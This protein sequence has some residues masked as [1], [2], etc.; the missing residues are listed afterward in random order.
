MPHSEKLLDLLRT[1]SSARYLYRH[2]NNEYV[3]SLRVVL[4]Q[5]GFSKDLNWKSLGDAPFYGEETVIAVRNFSRRNNKFTDGA[6]VSPTLL[7]QMVHL[8]DALVGIDLLQRA[9]AADQLSFSFVPTDPESFGTQQLIP[10]LK[11]LGIPF[12]DV[13][14]GLRTFARQQGLSNL[15][16]TRM[17]STLARALMAALKEKYGPDKNED[18]NQPAPKPIEKPEEPLK[19]RP[20]EPIDP[21]PITTELKIVDSDDYVLVSDGSTQVQFRKRDLGVVTYGYHT[22]D[23][24]VTSNRDQLIDAG[25]VPEGINVIEAVS[26]NEGRMDSINTYDR[27]F[28]SLG[29][30]QWTLG[31][32]F[33]EGELPALLKKVK[34]TYPRTFKAYFQNYGLDVAD[35]TN[36]TYGYI[37]LNGKIIESEEDKNQFRNPDWAFRFWRAS[38][39]ADVQTIQVKHALSR[40]K[41]F[42]WHPDFSAYGYPLNELV[43]STF[44]VALLLDNHVNRPAWV[45][46][47]IKEAMTQTGLTSNP[48]QWTVREESRLLDSYLKIREDYSENGHPPMT[49]AKERGLVI[50]AS[51]NAGELS[52]ERHSFEIRQAKIQSYSTPA[53]RGFGMRSAPPTVLGVE[54]P[55]D[56]SQIDYPKIKMEIIR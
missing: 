47:C 50:Q 1:H 10:M 32:G 15:S 54:P 21:D 43:T 17:T 30:Y 11:A 6:A 14:D 53:K 25:V 3:S 52:N 46:D 55:S 40:L 16:G 12:K 29:V 13:P 44:G 37:T 49:K 42:Y 38:Q 8:T 48:E 9:L 34:S 20:I 41:N 28:M 56:F 31:T 35:E 4:H 22:V 7:L 26:K 36:S 24:F 33:G 19:P 18:D 51:L 39:E 27:G 5:L 2:A 23:N 45:G